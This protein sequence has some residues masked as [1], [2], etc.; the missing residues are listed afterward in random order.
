M[1]DDWQRKQLMSSVTVSKVL[2]QIPESL[3]CH[4]Q[5]LHSSEVAMTYYL[6]TMHRRLGTRKTRRIRW[7]HI[8]CHVA[9]FGS[10][11]SVVREFVAQKDL[12]CLQLRRPTL[13]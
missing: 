2:C 1:A 7:D 11:L 3:L 6:K 13:S 9:C 4:T 12:E 5:A 10:R 8:R